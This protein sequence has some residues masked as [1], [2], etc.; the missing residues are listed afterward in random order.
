MD[1][2]GYVYINELVKLVNEGN[3]KEAIINDAVRRILRVKFELGLFDNP[4]NGLLMAYR[5]FHLHV[6]ARFDDFKL[7]ANI[8]VY[9]SI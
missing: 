5:P 2:E 7:F 9:H 4:Y 1:M 6:Q 8:C 3:V